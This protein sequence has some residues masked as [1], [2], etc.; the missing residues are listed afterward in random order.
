MSRSA[1]A[2]PSAFFAT[3]FRLFLAG[4]GMA[5]GFYT[6]ANADL[7]H[8]SIKSKASSESPVGLFPME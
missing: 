4:M 1:E 3:A 8:P 7:L 6:A 5:T 2:M